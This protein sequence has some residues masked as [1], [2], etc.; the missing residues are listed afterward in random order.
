M[1]RL[2]RPRH[3][4]YVQIVSDGY[5]CGTRIAGLPRAHERLSDAIL[6]VGGEACGKASVGDRVTSEFD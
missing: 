2:L 4:A 1:Q 3:A 6:S 5:P